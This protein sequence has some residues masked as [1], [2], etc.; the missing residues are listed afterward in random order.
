[1]FANILNQYICVAS[2]NRLTL[3]SNPIQIEHLQYGSGWKKYGGRIVAHAANHAHCQRRTVGS[4]PNEDVATAVGFGEPLAVHVVRT[5]I[6]PSG[7]LY[8]PHIRLCV[9][10][11]WSP[12]PRPYIGHINYSTAVAV[13]VQSHSQSQLA[14][15]HFNASI[16]T[17]TSPNKF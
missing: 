15:F 6:D 4:T 7:H 1:M 3:F 11:E 2:R 8:V 5:A 9:S 13:A 17:R 14:S 10:G 16:E 12:E